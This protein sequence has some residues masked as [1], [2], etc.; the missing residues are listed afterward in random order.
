MK[1]PITIQQGKITAGRHDVRD[2]IAKQKDG[3][4]LIEIHK[5]SRTLEQNST[6]WLWNQIIGDE[7]GYTKSEIHE[8][9]LDMF[10]PVI[11]FSDLNGKPKQRKLRSSEMSV[12]QMSRYLDQID[13]FAAEQSII[14]RQVRRNNENSATIN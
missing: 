12:E 10:A 14:L 4:Y 9:L 11:T 8:I 1:I 3:R 5:W 2:H 7:L 6:M 13:R